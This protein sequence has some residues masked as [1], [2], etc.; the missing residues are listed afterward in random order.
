MQSKITNLQ[1]LRGF[2]VL[3]VVFMHWRNLEQLYRDDGFLP[4]WARIGHSGV[5]LFF[6]ISGF[7]MVVIAKGYASDLRTAGTFLYHRWARIYPTYWF[8]FL[9]SLG[10]YLLA[11]SWLN[12]ESGE[13]PYLIESFF[14]LPTWSAQLLPVSWTLKYELYFYLVF[15]T[16]IL[17]PPHWR[18]AALLAWGGYMLGGQALCYDAP[19]I[20]CNKDLFLSVSPLGLEFLFGALAARIY[21]RRRATHA[22][23]ATL[24]G[25]GLMTAGW[26]IYIWSGL[27][28]DD[29]IWYRVLLF[30]LPAAVLLYG[31]VELERQR[32]IAA[33]RWLI[34]IGNASY[35]IYLSHLLLLTL[36]FAKLPVIYPFPTPLLDAMVLLLTLSVGMLAYRWVEQPLL[37]L[38][39]GRS[40]R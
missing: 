5:D 3:L 38:C 36:L 23:A 39:R 15:S 7:I 30:G 25:V 16:M 8:W 13:I 29:N 11:P 14:L 19:E 21:L 37:R 1:G 26:T 9:V 40:S 17:L 31:C 27:E 18:I 2:A 4:D 10:I 24:A 34:V 32:G 12:L 20:Q 6:V 33:P 28:L 22:L 35:S